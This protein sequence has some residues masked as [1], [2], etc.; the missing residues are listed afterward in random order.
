MSHPRPRLQLAFHF[1]S[2]Y[3]SMLHGEPRRKP[4]ASSYTLTRLSCSLF[5]NF[6]SFHR[7]QTKLAGGDGQELKL[8]HFPAQPEPLPT[9]YTP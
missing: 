8:V 6:A 3:F 5:L 2:I 4:D 1:N 9:Q 7:S